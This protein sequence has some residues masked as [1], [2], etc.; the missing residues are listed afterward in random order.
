MADVAERAS[1]VS[2]TS[3]EPLQ[4]LRQRRRTALLDQAASTAGPSDRYVQMHVG[5]DDEVRGERGMGMEMGEE[6]RLSDSE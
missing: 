1:Q 4:D 3:S 2:E 6:E 5:S